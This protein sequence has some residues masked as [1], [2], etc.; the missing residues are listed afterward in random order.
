[1]SSSALRLALLPGL[2]VGLVAA[3]CA[4]I[5][6]RVKLNPDMTATVTERVR[7]TKRLLDLAGAEGRAELLKMLGKDAALRRM[8]HMGKGVKLVSHRVGDAE[9]ASKESLTVFKIRRLDDFRYVSPWL[10]YST[11]PQ[12][13][14]ISCRVEPILKNRDPYNERPGDMAVS[15]LHVK[16]PPRVPRVEELPATPKGMSPRK[17][18]VYR[19]L[20][21]VFRDMLKGFKLRLTFESYAP[22]KSRLGVRNQRAGATEVDLINFSDKNLDSWGGLFLKNE[23]L[24]LD[25]VRWDLASADI[26]K[27]VKGFV[28]NHTL[29]VFLRRGGHGTRICFRPSR[30]FFDK[31]LAG[32]TITS[33]W[34]RGRS[35]K[36]DFARI[37]WH[38]MKKSKPAAETPPKT[39]AGARPKRKA[40]KKG[41]KK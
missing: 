10:A 38:P 27:H 2:L 36:A 29:P 14:V 17:L 18:Q 20:G 16:R 34:W 31:Y 30:P 32:K 35:E 19:E 13:N 23:E 5:E 12:N 40:K 11:Y 3:G 41:G 28:G 22:V 21:P 1:V 39:E 6:T 9:G 24:M 7:F 8:K 37:G 4:Q 15:F 33:P 26:G 25:L